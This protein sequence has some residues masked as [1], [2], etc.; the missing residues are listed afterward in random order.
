M[1]WAPFAPLLRS[2]ALAGLFAAAGCS[3]GG[4]GGGVGTPP[5]P[6]A[7]APTPAPAPAPTPTPSVDYDTSEYRATAGAVSMNALAAYSHG[8]TGAGV[9]VG[10]ID[11]GIATASPEFEGRIDAASTDT[12]GNGSI[13]DASGHGTAVAF[14][15]AGRRNGTGTQGVAFDS[16]LIVLR[17]DA[18]GS[19]ANTGSDGDSGCQHNDNSIAQALDVA[20]NNGARVVNISLGGE[21]PN[22]ALRQALTRATNAGVVVV[23]AAGNDGAADPDPFSSIATEAS[24]SHGLVVIAGSVGS[25]DA[26]SSFSNRAGTGAGQFLAAVGESVRA[27]DQTGQIF[28]W[29]GTS[30]AAPQISGAVALLAQAFPNL[31]GAQIVNL[32]YSSARDAGAAGV[33]PVYGH[34][35]LDLAKAFEPVGAM[36]VAGTKAA[37]S[38]TVNGTLSAPMGDAQQA[39]M[40]AIV[41]D[42]YSRAYAMDLARTIS[43]DGPARRLAGALSIRERGFS[44]AMKGV[45]VAVSIRPGWT[46]TL[47]GPMQLVPEDADRARLLA[48]SVTAKLGDRISFAFSSSDSG[49]ALAARLAGRE[50]PAFLV[51]QDATRGLGF[52]SNGRGA[53]ALRRAFGHWG[54]SL[55]ADTGD[56]L[57]WRAQRGSNRYGY[58]RVTLALDRRFGPLRAGL[59]LTRL[60]EDGTLLGAH[61]T[62]ALGGARA[63][64]DFVDASLR[65]DLGADWSLGASWR[66]G[67]TRAQ[68]TGGLRGSGLI[69]TSAFSFDV[70]KA[71]VL[72]KYD[73]FGL[74]IAQPLRVSGGGLDLL[75]PVDYDYATESVSAWG[76]QRLNLAPTGREM[77]FE[78]GYSR[79]LL[80]GWV[81][82]NLFLRRDP[83]NFASLPDDYGAAMRFTL[84]L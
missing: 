19:C 74:R 82:L 61:F 64:T 4:G 33:D 57:S 8:A 16:Q 27:P 84:G 83:G 77:N 49:G 17:T 9:K 35:V 26:I 47:V 12:A 11:S 6:V 62:G 36:S 13:E 48:A 73:R 46:S 67:W 44:A 81:D 39:P 14:T 53:A 40:G 54:V 58:G 60:R 68:L 79:G 76:S 25:G 10:V 71:R 1:G 31:T 5:P 2:A 69:R 80:A 45:T 21:A 72:D 22:L 56:V 75:L 78:L 18:P 50:D 7:P 41:L 28:L 20:T 24:V 70:G 15:L 43:R 55:A 52:D 29:D 23:I 34:G 32:L 30:L 42:G 51:A 66:Q 3:G 65:Y 37:T 63:D 38:L 59:A